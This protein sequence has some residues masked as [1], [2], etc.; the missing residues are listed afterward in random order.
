[1][2]NS[3]LHQVHHNNHIPWAL[4]GD[5]PQIASNA[6]E[7]KM[8]E[9][10]SSENEKTTQSEDDTGQLNLPWSWRFTINHPS[11]NILG[12]V[13]EGVQTRS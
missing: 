4:Y 2:S 3:H 1:M 7:N 6:S 9:L 5:E 8:D 10:S 12:N 11:T 13:D